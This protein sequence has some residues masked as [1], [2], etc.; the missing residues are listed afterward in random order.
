[1]YGQPNSPPSSPNNRGSDARNTAS[2][3]EVAEW[4]RLYKIAD[5]DGSGNIDHQELRQLMNMLRQDTTGQ[6]QVAP[7][8]D[9]EMEMIIAR[10]DQ[11]GDREISL[12]EFIDAMTFFSLRVSSLT[13]TRNDATFD[14]SSSTSA[15]ITSS[16]AN[17]FQQ[18][19]QFDPSHADR[20]L[21]RVLKRLSREEQ[22]GGD[23][24]EDIDIFWLTGR[25]PVL[26]TFTAEMKVAGLHQLAQ[27]M[28]EGTQLRQWAQQ[29]RHQQDMNVVDQILT[30]LLQ[31]LRIAEW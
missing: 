24:A 18:F 16:M 15:K 22:A 4:T 7:V 14:D 23:D 13:G 28:V 8:S 20:W 1:M 19:E 9:R 12:S 10:M 30:F 26:N 17:F 21:P 27:L 25:A 2:Q 3:A 29:L 5:A 6:T 11:N 31:L